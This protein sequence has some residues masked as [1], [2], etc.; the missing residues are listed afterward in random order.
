MMSGFGFITP[1]WACFTYGASINDLYA[2]RGTGVES[3]IR[4]YAYYIQK[5][6]WA[7]IHHVH[8]CLLTDLSINIYHVHVLLR[9]L[10][11]MPSKNVDSKSEEPF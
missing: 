8:V 11:M 9:I 2:P 3:P 5:K 6:E 1:A 10:V 7:S 4:V